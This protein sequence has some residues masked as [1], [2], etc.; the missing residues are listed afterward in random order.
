[1]APPAHGPPI[2]MGAGR[3]V[4]RAAQSPPRPFPGS[5][6]PRALWRERRR[7]GGR[8]R[9]PGWC[10]RCLCRLRR[11]HGTATAG[12]FPS[13]GGFLVFPAKQRHGRHGHH[14]HHRRANT[15][16]L[17]GTAATLRGRETPLIWLPWRRSSGARRARGG[18]QVGGERPNEDESDRRRGGRGTAKHA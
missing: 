18:H 15:V 3:R 10:R 13:T 4:F 17:G 9:R 1:M 6:L 14:C 11:W 12:V 8:H 5:A 7:G 16:G 2:R